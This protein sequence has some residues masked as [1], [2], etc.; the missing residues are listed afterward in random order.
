MKIV[1]LTL[2]K[3]AQ[4]NA[5]ELVPVQKPA[6]S[7]VHLWCDGIPNSARLVLI[8]YMLLFLTGLHSI[9]GHTCV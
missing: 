2:F 6:I 3:S 7:C 5:E 1:I 8:F 9:P 4:T